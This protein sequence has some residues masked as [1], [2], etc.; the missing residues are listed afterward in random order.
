MV[1]RGPRAR[2]VANLR[3]AARARVR[4]GPGG[5]PLIQAHVAVDL[6]IGGHVPRRRPRLA[7][8]ALRDKRAA[9][10]TAC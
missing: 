5:A 3:L 4:I 1:V 9:C 10:P 6:L 2:S 7:D 8:R